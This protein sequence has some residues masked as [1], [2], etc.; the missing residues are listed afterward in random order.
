MTL[1]VTRSFKFTVWKVR[2]IMIIK[3]FTRKKVFTLVDACLALKQTQD[4]CKLTNLINLSRPI[5][6]R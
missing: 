2:N 1:L 6:F 4:I 3:S 5:C